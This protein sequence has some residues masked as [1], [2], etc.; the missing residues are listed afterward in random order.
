MLCLAALR[1]GDTQA[2]EVRLF[3]PQLNPEAAKHW[4]EYAA[5][6]GA[7]V[8]IYINSGDPVPALSWKQPIP[9]TAIEKAVSAA[10]LSNPITGAATLG[11]ALFNAYFDS[12]TGVM[13]ATLKSYGFEVVRSHLKDLHCKDIPSAACHSMKLYEQV[14][15]LE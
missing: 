6:T 10:W 3:G 4:Q 1:S 5:K 7:S 8:K 12:K 9:Q 13:D 11:D 2:K 15:K 14:V